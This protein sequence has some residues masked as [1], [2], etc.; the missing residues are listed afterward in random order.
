MFLGILSSIPIISAGCCLWVLGGGGI[1]LVLLARQRALNSVTYGD[2]AFV[3]VLSGLFG[4]VV[5]TVLQMASHVIA[6][7][8]FGSQQQQLEDLLNKMGADPTTKDFVLRIF[9]GEVSVATVLF[10]FISNVIM[11]S[12]FAMIGAILAKAMLQRREAR[13]TKGT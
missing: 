6:A 9:S 3:G 13:S 12:L 11:F 2:A 8:F 10:T 7:Q 5:G 4:S 1:A